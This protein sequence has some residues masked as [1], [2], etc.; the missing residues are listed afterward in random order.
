MTA[1]ADVGDRAT[2]EMCSIEQ[3]DQNNQSASFETKGVVVIYVNGVPS[4]WGKTRCGKQVGGL[5]F[6]IVV[7]YVL[8]MLD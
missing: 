1:F 3:G 2:I 5:V 4:R 6:I 8:D 7:E